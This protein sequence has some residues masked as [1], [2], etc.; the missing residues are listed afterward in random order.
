MKNL[1]GSIRSYPRSLI[2]K[3][4]SDSIAG[5]NDFEIDRFTRYL[6]SVGK[7]PAARNYKSSLR[8]FSSWI[9]TRKK[10]FDTF[11]VVDAE[12]FMNSLK[13]NSTANLFLG[14]IRGYMKF[15][16]VTL[17][18]G[19]P[20]V[21]IETQRENQLRGIRSR[22]K[23]TKREKVAL[24]I[25]DLKE[26]LSILDKKPKTPRNELIYSGVLI[27]FFFGGRSIELGKWLRTSGV[28]HPAEI[29]WKSNTMQ[30]YTAKTGVYRFL[31]WHPAITPHLKRWCTALP[32][33]T[34]PNEW[35]TS[36]I[37][38]YTIRGVHI[39]AK[40]GRRTVQTQFRLS[41]I[42]DHITDAI[43]GHVHSATSEIYM[44]FTA[45]E[46]QIK[47]AMTRDHYMIKGGILH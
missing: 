2:R 1:H 46:S 6:T 10:T 30:L 14:A 39:T 29:D 12:E 26:F 23:R 19:Y 11:T 32:T 42:P 34:F 24:T 3:K 45:L 28:E 18:T 4:N 43:L 20:Q 31:A 41:G 8:G 44:D 35:L 25:D 7:I 9:G 38:G 40:T 17:P 33:F 16:N 21:L 15:R 5:V 27:H 37:T 22:S 36:R 13:K 47:E